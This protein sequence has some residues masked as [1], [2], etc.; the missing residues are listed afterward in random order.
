[1][2]DQEG[3]GTYNWYL[4]D[5]GMPRAISRSDAYYAFHDAITNI[6]QSSN[7]CGLTDH[8]SASA[9]YK[10]YTSYDA[11]YGGSSPFKCSI[12]GRTLGKGDVLGLCSRY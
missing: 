5:G 10:G 8:V 2:M 12:S 9:S 7:N 1:M 4:G 3:Y 6:T 11:M